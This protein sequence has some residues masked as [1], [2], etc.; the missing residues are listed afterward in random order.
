MITNVTVYGPGSGKAGQINPYFVAPAGNP[1]ATSE[2]ISWLDLL[3]GRLRHQ[4]FGGGR[5]LWHVRSPTTTLTS[6]WKLTFDRCGG[7]EPEQSD[8][9]QRLLRAP[10]PISP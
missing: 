3:G 8:L 1:T 7:L 2:Q 9:Q 4:Q 6:N 5:R 10:A